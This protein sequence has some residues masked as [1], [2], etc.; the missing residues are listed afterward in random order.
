MGLLDDAASVISGRSSHTNKRS[1]SHRS[2]RHHRSSEHKEHKEHRE[3]RRSGSERERSRS[4]HRSSRSHHHGGSKHSDAGA[5]GGGLGGMAAGLGLG[6]IAASIFGGGS[7][8]DSSDSDSKRKKRHSSSRSFFE[9]DDYKKRS[10]SKASFFNLGNGSRSSFFG[11]FGTNGAGRSPSFYKRSP[12]PNFVSRMLRKLKR[13]LRDLV[14][15]AKSHPMKVFMLV[16]MPLVTT[17]ALTALL[18][19]FG[20]RLPK[21]L[22]RMLGMA[23]KATTGD[24]VGLVGE[25]VRMASDGLGGNSRGGGSVFNHTTAHV[26]RGRDGNFQWERRTVEKDGYGRGAGGWGDGLKGLAKMFS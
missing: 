18:A 16:I 8:D 19:R 2:S 11:G 12:R 15:Y 5:G 7:D 9:G 26:E 1:K 14:Y 13:L 22:E 23:A 24:S 10:S 4:R 6:G 3:H 17:G 20:L 21:F 25:A